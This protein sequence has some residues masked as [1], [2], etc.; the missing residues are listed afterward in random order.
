MTHAGDAPPPPAA[1]RARLARAA[2]GL[3][4]RAADVQV[5]PLT[6]RPHQR[7]AA[8]RLRYALGHYGVA[9]LADDVGLGKTAVALA[10]ARDAAD[11][12]IVAPAA[13]R[14]HWAAALHAAGLARDLVSTEALGRD[15][16]RGPATPPLVIVDE[17][18]H[19]RN[20]RTRRWQA[21]AALVANGRLL[22]LT[23]T[24][25]HNRAEDLAALFALTL[26]ARGRTLDAST[27]A[28]LVVRRSAAD[29]RDGTGG[30]PPA[31]RPIVA[32]TSWIDLDEAPDVLDALRTLPPA[33]VPADGSPT[34][35]LDRYTLVR[36]WA[37]SDA[38]LRR[39]V[40][41]RLARALAVSDA[42]DAGHHPTRADLHALTRTLDTDASTVQL[43]LVP[44]A[45]DGP[46]P[47][48][49]RAQI[50]AHVAALRRVVAL[51]ARAAGDAQRVA[52]LRAIR[53]RHPGTRIVAFSH[54][55]N[56]VR[57]LYAALAPDGRVAMLT[58]GG[59][60]IASGRLS[61]ADVLARFAPLGQACAPPADIER[62]DLLLTTDV[63]S[64]G[65][66][67][68]DAS[69][70]VHLDLP[71]TPARLAQ[72]TGRAVRPGAPAATVYVH[73]FRPPPALA[74]ELRLA[75]HARGKCRAADQTVGASALE[76]GVAPYS[77]RA[78]HGATL[79]SV[80]TAAVAELARDRLLERWSAW[81]EP[82]SATRCEGRPTSN[83]R[84]IAA[85]RCGASGYLAVV[86]LPTRLGAL[87]VPTL[88][89]ALRT[90]GPTS[91][92][93]TVRRALAALARA[94]A[95]VTPSPHHVAAARR[96]LAR[97]ARH[98]LVHGA[99]APSRAA[100]RS[101]DR[102]RD[103]GRDPRAAI[104]ARATRA[105]QTAAPDQRALTSTAAGALRAALARPLSAE[106]EAALRNVARDAR[107]DAGRSATSDA[108]WLAA[109][110]R[111]AAAAGSGNEGDRTAARATL[112]ALVLLT[113]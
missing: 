109:A 6:L 40:R 80:T 67:L 84:V 79:T 78:S 23:A 95:S 63:L 50:G 111:L 9:L 77:R 100:V 101:A 27:L 22:L 47:E 55:A 104:L 87:H 113:P 65:L 1:I 13:L 112:R 88:V 42:L 11:A 4:P 59:G 107:D 44:A 108:E 54:S 72:R 70:V 20:P 26:G 103:A 17:A 52:H 74:R 90:R 99:I 2:L 92:P 98:Q 18:H 35:D 37:S 96:A 97:W 53:A 5:G 85:V 82:P 10:L 71:W 68:R 45:L 81:Q 15:P 34:P 32:P 94:D 46:A 93:H 33:V 83:A 21:L 66:D 25:V 56:T 69:V 73:A 8:A 19:F 49:A 110:V 14:A 3:A 24:P 58:A 7:H 60:R 76:R 91:A 102:T 16:P 48:V 31:D 39:A 64:E 86:A 30:E 105:L 106:R 51:L 62:I 38:A 28:R 43:S 36:L 29:V 61:R 75:A 41:R 57:A 89:A 12:V